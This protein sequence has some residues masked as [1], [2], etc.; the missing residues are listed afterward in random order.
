MRWV[1]FLH[2]YQPIDQ[3]PQIL[4]KV[5]NESYRPI[6][7]S[8]K[9]NSRARI[10]ININACL[11]EQLVKHYPDVLRGIARLVKKGQVE[12]V[13]SAKHHA[14]LPLIPEDEVIRQIDLGIQTNTR[15][16]GEDLYQPSGFFPTELAYAPR[17]YRAALRYKFKYILVDEISLRGKLG[18]LDGSRLYVTPPE[19]KN[20]LVIPAFRHWT[21][22]LRGNAEMTNDDFFWYTKQQFSSQEHTLITANDAELFGHHL[23][24]RLSLLEKTFGDPEI[25][26]LTIS[27]YISITGGISKAKAVSLKASTWETEE[28]D[29][30]TSHQNSQGL[31]Y[32]LW[33]NKDNPIQMLQWEL[34]WIAI[35][36]LAKFPRPDDDKEMKWRSARKHLDQGLHSCFWWW[37]SCR[38]WWNPDMVCKGAEQLIRAIR[39]LE[40]VSNKKKLLADKVYGQIVQVTWQWHWSGEAQR[41]IDEFEKKRGHGLYWVRTEPVVW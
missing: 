27:D 31:P 4:K 25:E 9:E 17:V 29:L 38:P 35:A 18:R 10:S 37:A 36:E 23:P 5:V 20:L 21:H 13:A 11:T 7:K 33:F 30:K 15:I 1:L 2:F 34:A 22:Q 16:F 26:L 6:I 40:F 14:F 24:K 41:R 3:H 8:L 28:E 32:P 39:S 12:L 19:N